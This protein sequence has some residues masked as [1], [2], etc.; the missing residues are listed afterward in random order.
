MAKE[1]DEPLGILETIPPRDKEVIVL[2]AVF[3]WGKYMRRQ[4]LAEDFEPDIPPVDFDDFL[5]VLRAGFSL[6]RQ[7]N[8]DIDGD[9]VGS[10]SDILSKHPRR[11][12]LFGNLTDS[13]IR[14]ICWELDEIFEN[15]EFCAQCESWSY[16]DAE[17]EDFTVG[18]ASTMLWLRGNRIGMSWFSDI[19]SGR[20]RGVIV[21]VTLREKLSRAFAGMLSSDED[22]EI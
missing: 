12:E 21:E 2:G 20:D 22:G 6:H 7:E 19:Y 11:Q 15:Q 8:V 3:F 16:Y 14:N 18:V 5:S 1:L 17:P 4:V 13:D 9:V 10:V